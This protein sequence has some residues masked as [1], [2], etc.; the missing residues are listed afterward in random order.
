VKLNS[1]RTLGRS[2]LR[3]SPI[4]LGTM[5]LGDGSWGADDETSIA[6]LDRYLDVG[7]N[8]LD[9]A[10]AYND[11]RSEKPSAPTWTSTRAC[12]TGW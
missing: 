8:F 1:F 4:T 2:G 6:I 9:T 7:G 3:V 12:G 5:T 11:G 10:N